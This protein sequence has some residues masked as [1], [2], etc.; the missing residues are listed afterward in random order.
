MNKTTD[1]RGTVGPYRVGAPIRNPD[2]IGIVRDWQD[3]DE[4]GEETIAEVL[5]TTP[6]EIG[7]ADARLLSASWE[8]REALRN[9]IPSLMFAIDALQAPDKCAMRENLEACKAALHK[10]GLGGEP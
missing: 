8:M 10:A 9:A 6:P 3:G 2:A 7:E 1:G 4:Q 5:P